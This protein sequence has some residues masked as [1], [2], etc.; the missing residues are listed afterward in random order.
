MADFELMR[1]LQFTNDSKIVML[2][3]DGL[4]GLPLELGGPTELEAA[5]TPNLDRLAAGSLCGLSVPIGP[6]I[7]PGS[8]PAHLALFGYDPLKYEIGRGI[9]EALGIGFDLHDEDVAAR[10]NF[11]TVDE[12][13]FITDRRAGRIPTEKNVELC[14]LLRDVKL[15]GVQVFLEA[16]KEYRFVLVLRGEGLVDGLTPGRVRSRASDRCP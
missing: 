9:L 6:G 14:K 7:T 11:C 16:V 1:E 13:G 4:G 15:P 2:V 8:G 3:I 5:R 12:K 10:G